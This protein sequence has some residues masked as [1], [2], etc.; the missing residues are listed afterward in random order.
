[1]SIAP[2]TDAIAESARS[3]QLQRR[4]MAFLQQQ[5]TMVLKSG[6]STLTFPLE[7]NRNDAFDAR[8]F[9]K[10]SSPKSWLSCPQR[11][12]LQRWRPGYFREAYNPDRRGPS[13][14][15]TWMA[16][17]DSG[18]PHEPERARPSTFA[19]TLARRRSTSLAIL[20]PRLYVG[21]C[22]VDIIQ[23]IAPAAS[24]AGIVQGSAFPSNRFPPDDQLE[25]SSPCY[26]RASS[27]APLAGTTKFI[28][29]NNLPTNLLKR[30]SANLFELWRSFQY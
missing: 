30:S 1:M 17:T 16:Q 13:S 15:T 18:R 28:G 29:G 25:W 11:L 8:N 14:S 20:L 23:K 6:S 9:F 21:C 10:S 12:W 22:S 27:P 4:S 5:H 3:L 2:S 24:T 7:F 19:E 26:R